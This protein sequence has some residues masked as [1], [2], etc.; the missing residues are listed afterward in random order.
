MKAVAR[1][2]FYFAFIIPRG[3]DWPSTFIRLE[4]PDLAKTVMLRPRPLDEDLFPDDIDRTL[5]GLTFSMERLSQPTGSMKLIVRDRYLDRVEARVE[6]EVASW[7]DVAS[8]TVQESFESVAIRA[9][10]SFLE[11]CRVL[12]GTPFVTGVERHFRLQDRRYYVLNPR[13]ITWFRGDTGAPLPAYGG[14]VNGT[15]SSG[16]IRSPESGQIPLRAL[17]DSLSRDELPPLELSLLMDAEEHLVLLRFREC[18]LSLASACEVASNS[19]IARANKEGNATVKS[20]LDGPG[21]FADKR[22]HRISNHLSGRSL[23][24]E[25]ET[26]FELVETLYRERNDIIHGRKDPRRGPRLGLEPSDLAERLGASSVGVN[27]LGSLALTS[28]TP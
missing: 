12:A 11:H 3:V 13:T 14:G 10:N 1:F 24:A 7:G 21:S 19:Y 27:W 17:K 25:N 15:M 23:K 8:P 20:I 26:S 5:S 28:R 16:A 2:H 22:F 18:I 6:G 9:T 4:F